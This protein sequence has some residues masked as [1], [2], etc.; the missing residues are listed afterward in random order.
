MFA[1]LLVPPLLYYE[2]ISDTYNSKNRAVAGGL[3]AP[4]PLVNM[5]P[6]FYLPI[7]FPLSSPAFGKRIVFGVFSLITEKNGH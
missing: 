2:C 3:G 5:E 6:L 7:P 1:Q 4:G